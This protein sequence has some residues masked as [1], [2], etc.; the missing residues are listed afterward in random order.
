MM[1]QEGRKTKD[2]G[3][4]R[5]AKGKEREI[6][7]SNAQYYRRLTTRYQLPA[8]S[9]LSPWSPLFSCSLFYSARARVGKLRD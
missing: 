9:R 7:R 5:G 8:T 2:A 1:K 4:V 3:P 6:S